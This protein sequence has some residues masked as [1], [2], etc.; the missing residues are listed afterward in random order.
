MDVVTVNTSAKMERSG[1]IIYTPFP[2]KKN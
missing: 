1:N 2:R